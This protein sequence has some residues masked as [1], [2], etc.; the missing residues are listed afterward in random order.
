MNIRN[1]PLRQKS[2]VL[3]AATIG[4]LAA[5]GADAQIY[6]SQTFTVTPNTAAV[7]GNANVSTGGFISVGSV[8]SGTMTGS[9][10]VSITN[11]PMFNPANYHSG[12]PVF[13]VPDLLGV[14]LSLSSSMS[15]SQECAATG[16]V[17][18]ISVSMFADPFSGSLL[19]SQPS[20][21][22]ISKSV[23][24]GTPNTMSLLFAFFSGA[25]A[26]FMYQTPAPGVSGSSSLTGS[27]VSAFIG[28][29]DIPG[30][31]LTA[32]DNSA[33]GMSAYALGIALEYSLSNY[34][35]ESDNASVSVTYNLAYLHSA[36]GPSALAVFGPGMA[37]SLLA[38]RRRR[39]AA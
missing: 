35:A 11:L 36:P 9:N 19:L 34:L 37:T 28:T 1:V 18:I 30:V 14:T 22:T 38:L 27:G 16:D 31:N 15:F 25:S 39:R 13:T 4:A 29:G 3:G 10:S 2:F 23:A 5:S 7:S 33:A 32:V 17:A 24:P 26:N 6:T 12:N 8:I 21:P 20:L